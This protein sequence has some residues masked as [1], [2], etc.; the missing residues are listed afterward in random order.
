MVLLLTRNPQ[1]LCTPGKLWFADDTSS[2]T[3]RSFYCYTLE[4]KDRGLFDSMTAEEI[5]KIK[6]PGITCIPYG[7]YELVLNFSARFQ[8]AMPLLLNVKGFSGIR[9]H[10]GNIATQ[11]DGCVLVGSTQGDCFVGNSKKT[12]DRFME[13]I[14]PV[15][16]REKIF[17]EIKQEVNTEA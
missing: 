15:S 3:G 9:I 17:L 6:L 14:I 8:K 13:M 16:K 7:R 12:F 1:E 4:D 5:L 11:T 10:S 2:L